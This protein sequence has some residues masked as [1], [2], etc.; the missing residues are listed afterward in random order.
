MSFYGSAGALQMYRAG[1]PLTLRDTTDGASLEVL[2]L[3]SARATPTDNDEIYQS[4]YLE[5]DAS[6]QVEVGRITVRA[7]DVTAGNMDGR[8]VMSLVTGGALTDMWQIDSTAAGVIT[9]TVPTGDIILEDNVSVRFGSSGAESDLQSDSS[10]TV[11]NFILRRLK[12]S[13]LVTPC[14]KTVCCCNRS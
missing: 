6:A 12:D 5:D 13:K 8:M 9:T 1:L 10:N 14:L 11:W 3:S 7:T 4:F 2:R